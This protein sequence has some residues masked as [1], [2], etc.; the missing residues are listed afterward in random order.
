MKTTT[1]KNPNFIG[2]KLKRLEVVKKLRAIKKKESRVARK[3]RQKVRSE[4]G[5]KVSID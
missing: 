5:D 1:M 2:N 4:L 3:E